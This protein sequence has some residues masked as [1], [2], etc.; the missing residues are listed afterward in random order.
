MKGKIGRRLFHVAG[1]CVLPLAALVL[2]R[3]W[4]LLF[5]GTVTAIFVLAEALRLLF[6][7]VN[8]RLVSLFTPS[9]AFKEGEAARPIGSTYYLLGAF[10]TFLLFPRDVAI[11]AVLFVAVGDAAAATFGERFGTRKIGHKSLE[12]TAAF[13]ASALAIGLVL[14][15]AGLDLRWAAVATGALVAAIMELLPLPVDDNL[16]IPLASALAMVLVP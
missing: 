6:P 8:R 12:G 3:E 1:G 16:T 2:P 5:A 9:G 15:W 13:F 10:V 11:A 7:P 14:I 4:L